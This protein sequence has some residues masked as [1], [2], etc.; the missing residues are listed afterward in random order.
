MY[1]AKRDLPRA[2][3]FQKQSNEIR[4]RNLALIIA[5][6]SEQQK[7]L[8]M[9]TLDIETDITTTLHVRSAPQNNDAA[10]L[11]LTTILRRKGRILDAMTDSIA[12]LRRRSSPADRKLVERLAASRS[13]LS[14]AVLGGPTA[15]DIDHYAENLIRLERETQDLEAQISQRSAEFRAQS[16]PITLES[17]QKALPTDSVLIEIS[18][19]RPFN[20]L[21][22][23][24]SD[25][26]EAA[27]YVAYVLHSSGPPS[28]VELG[29][30]AAI[31][32][33][34]ASLRGLLSN[35]ATNIREAAREFDELVMRPIRRLIG[36]KKNLIL[37]CDGALNL[38]PFASLIDE[39]NRYL[40]E[41]YRITYLTSGRDLLRLRTNVASKQR[42]VIVAN[43]TF[44]RQVSTVGATTNNQR[45]SFDLAD[46]VFTALPGTAGEAS[47]IKR[48]LPGATLLTRTRA[49]ESA[50]KSVKGPAVLHVATHGFFLGDTSSSGQQENPLLRSGVVLAGANYRQGG[51]GE[52]GI[53]TALE[54]AGLDL[55]GTKIVVLSACE[56][57]VGE[58]RNGEGVYGLRRALMLAGSESQVISLW[59][60]DDLATRDLMV[61]YYALLRSGVGRSE[62]LQKVQLKMLHSINANRTVRRGIGLNS[63]AEKTD[64]SHPFY[65]AS[66]IQSGDWRRVQGF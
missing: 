42:P 29:D 35:P 58:V 48:I 52:D 9:D 15:A 25:A 27:R 24:K 23:T 8:Y 41:T 31:D 47:A 14:N 50:V 20:P 18:A 45:R 59:K 3:Q 60:V 46:A 11:A 28:W 66:F 33:H 26:T 36:D 61:G 53:L 2:I 32:N 21:A 19:Y 37:S 16:E 34:V 38:I 13:E 54:A 62:A 10:S 30:E 12:N 57:G 51:N 4:E 65:W 5:T 64:R 44:D 56:T 6:G 22:L 40:V 39:N 17:I 63:A 43:P 49:T 7:R 1:Q 55:W